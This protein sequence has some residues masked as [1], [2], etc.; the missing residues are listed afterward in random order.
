MHSLTNPERENADVRRGTETLNTEPAGD[1][2]SDVNYSLRAAPGTGG[3]ESE[4]ASAESSRARYEAR[5]EELERSLEKAHTDLEEAHKGYADRVSQVYR[6]RIAELEAMV[7][8]LRSKYEAGIDELER[9]LR[10]AREEFGK[11]L[12]RWEEEKAELSGECERLAALRREEVDRL[13]SNHRQVMDSLH[14]ANLKLSRQ[15]MQMGEERKAAEEASEETIEKLKRVIEE[16][17]FEFM[18]L[19]G[20]WDG[21]LDETSERVGALESQN[22]SLSRALSERQAEAAELARILEI[23]RISLR[24]NISSL[25]NIVLNRVLPPGTY[26]RHFCHII[27]SSCVALAR[28]GPVGLYRGVRDY[29]ANKRA[30]SPP[31]PGGGD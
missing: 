30:G 31:V 24:R 7:E 26:S 13:N 28:G 11:R 17:G 14:T 9:R 20:M 1:V 21:L 10:E 2:S 27:K 23:H 18:R 25:Y 8:E 3:A 19:Y 5:I 16:Y 15:L 6:P 22:A 29:F 4:E 12:S